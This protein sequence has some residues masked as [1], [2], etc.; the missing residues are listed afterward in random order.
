ML[1]MVGTAVEVSTAREELFTDTAQ[2]CDVCDKLVT[3]AAPRKP[4]RLLS[5][6]VCDVCDEK[7]E[8]KRSI[9]Q[10]HRVH[11]ARKRWLVATFPTALGLAVRA[12]LGSNRRGWPLASREAGGFIHG[13]LRE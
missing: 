9:T 8:K 2:G 7:R 4:L 5:C 3:S 1:P 11:T 13:R 6:D 12:C 10:T